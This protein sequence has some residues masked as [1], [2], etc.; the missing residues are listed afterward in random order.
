MPKQ[1]SK[2]KQGLIIPE[3]IDPIIRYVR[4]QRV[5]LDVDLARI[6]GVTTKRLNE[7]VKRNIQRFPDDFMFRLTAK[8]SKLVSGS[9]SQ[10]ATR[11]RS[12]IATGSEGKLEVANCDL[13]IAWRTTPSSLRVHGT[14]CCHGGEC[15]Q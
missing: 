6:Y 3:T 12:Q 14:R 2:K 5:V 9:E 4:G 8:E 13:K 1:A 15:A 7:Q 11:N 10:A